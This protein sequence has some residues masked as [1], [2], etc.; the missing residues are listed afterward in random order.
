MIRSSRTIKD[1]LDDR[2]AN[3]PLFRPFYEQEGK[4]IKE[5]AKFIYGL[6]KRVWTRW[7]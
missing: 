7:L 1:Y 5:C 3:D 4:S 2:A 6:G